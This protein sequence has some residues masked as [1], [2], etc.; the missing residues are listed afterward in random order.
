MTFTAGT[1]LGAYEILGPL[2]KG[3]MKVDPQRRGWH[4]QQSLPNDLYLCAI[5][6]WFES[7]GGRSYVEKA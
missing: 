7:L 6:K 5:M 4:R 2:G 3:R 1:K